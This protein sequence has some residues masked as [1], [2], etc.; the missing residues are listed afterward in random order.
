M[1]A[2]KALIVGDGAIGKTCLLNCFTSQTS[3][4]D[5]GVEPEYE[6]TTF[7]NFIL[8]WTAESGDTIEAEIWDTAGQEAFE[9]LRKLSYPNTDLFLIGFSND[10][11]TSLQ[12]IDH[13][14]IPEV[15]DSMGSTDLW[16]VL[17]GTKSDLPT[18]QVTTEQATA[19]AKKIGACAFIDTSA[20][21][22]QTGKKEESGVDE[23][24]ATL[25]KLAVMKRNNEKKPKLGDLDGAP[26][27]R[28]SVSKKGDKQIVDQSGKPV[29]VSQAEQDKAK[30][31]PAAAK[32][33]AAKPDAA[34]KP[35]A[36]PDAGKKGGKDKAADEAGCSC[37]LS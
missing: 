26:A 27:V 14:W 20:R 7:N 5:E 28:E 36:K 31:D 25:T 32:P 10:S 35:S 18:K 37:T 13:K 2:C 9:Q 1:S 4:W 6:P 23:L 12:N 34:T 15:T 17:V 16:I 24:V 33:A 19:T 8:N 30:K 22:Y 29:E 3:Q 21:N 11:S